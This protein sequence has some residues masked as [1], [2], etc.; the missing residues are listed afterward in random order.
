MKV[1][2]SNSLVTYVPPHQTNLLLAEWK[3][4]VCEVNTA[5]TSTTTNEISTFAVIRALTVSELLSSELILTTP[6]E[7]PELFLLCNNDAADVFESYRANL[8]LSIGGSGDVAW[9]PNA[10]FYLREEKEIKTT[11]INLLTGE[12]VSG[13]EHLLQKYPLTAQLQQP[14]VEAAISLGEGLQRALEVVSRPKENVAELRC[15][16]LERSVTTSHTPSELKVEKQKEQRERA[17]LTRVELPSPHLASTA[18]IYTP[19]LIFSIDNDP[20]QLVY[21]PAV[22][23]LYLSEVKGETT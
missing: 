23:R 12:P 14:Q 3:A 22:G 16:L 11:T 8:P 5:T 17:A 13:M 10:F 19:I 4:K 20:H 7:V 1:L 18:L 2:D 21:D 15:L 6:D 9:M